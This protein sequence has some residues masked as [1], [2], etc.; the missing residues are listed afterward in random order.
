MK[1]C[2]KGWHLPSNAEWTT[3][4]NYVESN[5]G[6]S[7]CAGKHLKSERGWN[8]NGGGGNIYGFSALPGGLGYSGGGF[9][10]VGDFG[11]WW[12]ASESRS[13]YAY[14]R[15]MF[16]DDE[17]ALYYYYDKSYLHSVRCVQD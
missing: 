7:D 14:S 13:S 15:L 2:P 11:Y 8:N 3:L 16:Y 9:F 17:D 12:S 1:A 5:S 6:C 10:G 4:T